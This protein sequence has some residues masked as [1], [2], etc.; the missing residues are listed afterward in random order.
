MA[1]INL[2]PWRS[3][4]RARRNKEFLTL[5]AAVTLLC[6]ITSCCCDDAVLWNELL[7]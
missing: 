3:E 2:L 5:V 6:R 4:E 1:R 7:L